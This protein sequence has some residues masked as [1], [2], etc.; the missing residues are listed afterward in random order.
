MEESP[1]IFVLWLIGL[2][3]LIGIAMYATA[4]LI[5]NDTMNYD[6]D[7]LWRWIKRPETGG[8]EGGDKGRTA[9]G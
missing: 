2:F 9:R 4:I 1:A 8:K 3:G 6:R 5:R 7:L